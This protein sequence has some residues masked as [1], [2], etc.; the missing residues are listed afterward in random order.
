[1]QQ[2]R[3]AFS[4]QSMGRNRIHND[5][6]KSQFSGKI[7]TIA[8]PISA[9]LKS[10]YAVAP[11]KVEFWGMVIPKHDRQKDLSWASSRP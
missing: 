1:M 9:S 8:V 10:K 4:L 5:P 2:G 3:A 7:K 11:A 6:E